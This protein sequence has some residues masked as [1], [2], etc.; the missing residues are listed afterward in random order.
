MF[1]I[2]PDV[3]KCVFSCHCPHNTLTRFL[4]V[5]IYPY[6]T[7]RVAL[8]EHDSFHDWSSFGRDAHEGVIDLTE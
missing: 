6:K 7:Q 4:M 1:F 2:P 3:V 8:C 5:N